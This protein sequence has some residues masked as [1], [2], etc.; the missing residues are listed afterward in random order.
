MSCALK[1]FS[2]QFSCFS[3]HRLASFHPHTQPAAAY[4]LCHIQAL[5]VRE[6]Q[7][8]THS[9]QRADFVKFTS[10]F[11]TVKWFSRNAIISCISKMF[12]ATIDARIS[13]A[14]QAMV[15]PFLSCLTKLR[16]I[17]VCHVH[18]LIHRQ[19]NLIVVVEKECRETVRFKD[20]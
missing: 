2:L 1:L 17:H 11:K 10:Y 5:G 6:R 7:Y 12:Y 13:T 20:S 14:G 19:K 16:A 8:F 9:R 4:H 3:R 18:F 15:G